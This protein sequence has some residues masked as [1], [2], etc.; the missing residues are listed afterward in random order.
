MAVSPESHCCHKDSPLF[1]SG[2]PIKL[3]LAASRDSDLAIFKGKR[4]LVFI[5][6]IWISKWEGIKFFCPVFLPLVT[7][8][9][10]KP[11][12]VHTAY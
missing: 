7:D 9:K 11:P 4:L 6:S 8:Y 12:E 3:H 1:L 5:R 10:M 2:V